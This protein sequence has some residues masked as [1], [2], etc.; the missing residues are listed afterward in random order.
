M[1]KIV[2]IMLLVLAISLFVAVGPVGAYDGERRSLDMRTAVGAQLDFWGEF[3]K[4][5]VQ[6]GAPCVVFSEETQF[7]IETVL[8]ERVATDR[9]DLV[10]GYTLKNE[11]RGKFFLG[12]QCNVS[13]S[14]GGIW[15]IFKT[16]KPTVYLIE[17]NWFLGARYEFRE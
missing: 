13:E 14:T 3:F 16:F 11:E 9:L 17:G 8:A 10:G 2:W 4:R 5:L 1:K 6:N 12:L 15:R 7:G